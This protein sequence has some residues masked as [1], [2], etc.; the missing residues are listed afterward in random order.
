MKI[1]STNQR[2]E[3]A[4]ILRWSLALAER[5]LAEHTP[6]WDTQSTW[7]N[8]LFRELATGRWW[9][10]YLADHAWAGEV[11]VIPEGPAAS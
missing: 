9:V 10:V 8:S 3:V 6:N 7:Q 4:D 2:D 11:L 1:R 5:G